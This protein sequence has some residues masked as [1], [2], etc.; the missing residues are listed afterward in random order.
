MHFHELI[1]CTL[2][3]LFGDLIPSL[4][5]A[6]TQLCAALPTPPPSRSRNRELAELFDSGMGLH[7]AGML[8]GDRS[9]TERLFSDGIIKVCG[10][11][12]VGG[13][14]GVIAYSESW[15]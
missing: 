14:K 3:L 8:R 2:L 10:L 6:K 5:V 12:G 11:G 7:H 9:L 1:I 4:P 15:V 13:V